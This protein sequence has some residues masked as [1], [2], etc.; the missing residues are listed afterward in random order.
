MIKI[1]RINSNNRAYYNLETTDQI[2]KYIVIIKYKGDIKL[3][4]LFKIF[5]YNNAFA[6][7]FV[8]NSY[9]IYLLNN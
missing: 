4:L 6:P 8:E 5:Y 3:W 7:R 9:W 1:I 2:V